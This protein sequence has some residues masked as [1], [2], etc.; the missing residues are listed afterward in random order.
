LLLLLVDGT[1][2][3]LLQQARP[4]NNFAVHL[5]FLPT[6]VGYGVGDA[7]ESA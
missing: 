2:G 3:L 1:P 4:V 7:R 5:S 6:K